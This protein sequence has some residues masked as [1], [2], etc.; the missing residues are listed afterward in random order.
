MATKEIQKYYYVFKI[1]CCLVT[2]KLIFY[3]RK[4]QITKVADPGLQVKG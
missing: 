4:I 3:L 2:C 1:L